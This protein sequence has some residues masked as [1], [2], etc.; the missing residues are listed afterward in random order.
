MSPKKSENINIVSHSKQ[1]YYW[2]V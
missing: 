1:N 2:F